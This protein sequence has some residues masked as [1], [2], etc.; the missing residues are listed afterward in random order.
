MSREY[1]RLEFTPSEKNNNNFVSN[2]KNNK[3]NINNNLHRCNLL[4]YYT[5]HFI[6]S[7]QQL[8]GAIIP[9]TI[10]IARKFRSK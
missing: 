5:F 3:N 9:L 1:K 2:N 4:E 7:Q 10:T 8:P 6:F